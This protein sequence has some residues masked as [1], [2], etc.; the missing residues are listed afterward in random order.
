MNDSK[1]TDTLNRIVRRNVKDK[2]K[3]ETLCDLFQY[4]RMNFKLNW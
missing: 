3:S 4:V 1:S 2:I